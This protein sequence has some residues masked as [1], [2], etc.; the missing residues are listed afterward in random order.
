MAGLYNATCQIE[1]SRS[2]PTG[3]KQTGRAHTEAAKET[4][5]CSFRQLSAQQVQSIFGSHQVEAWRCRLHRG[6]ADVP[7]Q[8]ALYVKPDG[9]SDYIEYRVQTSTRNAMLVLF[10]TRVA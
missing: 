3:A 1:R 4:V 8:S 9:G 6:V 7:A 2:Y 5:R 10:V